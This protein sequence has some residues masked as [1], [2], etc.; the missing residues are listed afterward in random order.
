MIAYD[1][2]SPVQVVDRGVPDSADQWH[3]HITPH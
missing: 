3:Y 1:A 2:P